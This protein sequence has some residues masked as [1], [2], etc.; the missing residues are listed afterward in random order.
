MP[1]YERETRVRAPLETVWEFYSRISG[2]E[3]LTPDWMHLH[4]EHVVD[5]AG[6]PDPDILDVGTQMRLALRP[7]GVGPRRRWFSRITERERRDGAAWFVDV[8]DRGPF[9]RWHHTHAFFGDGD[10]TLVS[11]RVDY[12]LP[13]G[14]LGRAVGPLGA[15]GFEPMF[16][17]RHR[18]T[19]ELLEG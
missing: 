7:F 1:V 13:G 15:V 9:P 4:V 14:S 18:R 2:L 10:A 3:A 17:Y 19:R 6:N 5:A 16:R 11:D 8:M 12:E